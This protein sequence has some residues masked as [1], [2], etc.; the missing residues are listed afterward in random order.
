M[1]GGDE[2]EVLPVLRKCLTSVV[3]VSEVDTPFWMNP[4]IVGFVKRF[5]VILVCE[6]FLFATVVSVQGEDLAVF[7]LTYV[8]IAFL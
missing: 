2:V 6:R 4:E 7:A 3:G 1:K 8:E 5:T